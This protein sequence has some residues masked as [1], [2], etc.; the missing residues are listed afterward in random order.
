MIVDVPSNDDV[1]EKII[2]IDTQETM[3]VNDIKENMCEL[4]QKAKSGDTTNVWQKEKNK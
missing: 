2:V 3:D 4:V 1:V